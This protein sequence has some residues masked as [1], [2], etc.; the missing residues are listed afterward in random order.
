MEQRWPCAPWYQTKKPESDG[1]RHVPTSRPLGHGDIGMRLSRMQDCVT[2]LE[3]PGPYI[4][5]VRATGLEPAG[6]FEGC[7]C[8]PAMKQPVSAGEAATPCWHGASAVTLGSV[9]HG[10][11]QKQVLDRRVPRAS[12][13]VRVPPSKHRTESRVPARG[14]AGDGKRID[15]TDALPGAGGV[16]GRGC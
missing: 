10:V 11:L 14:P 2:H 12:F 3:L 8:S 15:P 4:G 13:P 7:R 6:P 1:L 5:P 9:T 16:V